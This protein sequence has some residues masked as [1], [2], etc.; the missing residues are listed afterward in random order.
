MQPGFGLKALGAIRVAAQNR[1]SGNVMRPPKQGS[2]IAVGG[3]S[4]ALGAICSYALMNYSLKRELAIFTCTQDKSSYPEIHTIL[5][6]GPE[7]IIVNPNE[8][9]TRNSFLVSKD[10]K[11]TP[12]NWRLRGLKTAR[13]QWSGFRLESNDGT[14]NPIIREVSFDASTQRLAIT[15]NKDANGYKPDDVN[16]TCKQQGN[17]HALASKANNVPLGYIRGRSGKGLFMMPGLANNTFN[18]SIL[19]ELKGKE[20]SEYGQYQLLS[21]R[22]L[23]QMD[24]EERSLMENLK[25]GLISRNTRQATVWEFAGTY[26]YW[27]QYGNEKQE[28]NNNAGDWCRGNQYSTRS[29]YENQGYKLSSS[30]PDKRSTYGWAKKLYPD[31]RYAGYVNYKAECDGTTYELKLAGTVDEIGQNSYGGS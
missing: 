14:K 4:I 22:I 12:L 25:E 27:W 17:Y 23:S 20:N 31:G 11:E 9:W 13:S 30:R 8:T 3:L 15:H 1:G 26:R 16:V 18:A 28:A 21:R 2:I 24:A 7:Y 19:N 10:V 29:E 5:K 6:S